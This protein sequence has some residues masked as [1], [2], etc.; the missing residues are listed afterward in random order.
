MG[1]DALFSSPAVVRAAAASMGLTA[2]RLDYCEADDTL[3]LS[4][5]RH[6]Q[7]QHIPLPTGRTF[8][9]D[10][11]VKLLFCDGTGAPT[12]AI[13]AEISADPP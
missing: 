2:A 3:Y 11:I 13:P 9:R 8:T 12:V 10:Q 4:I 1:I 7:I 6:G 5:A